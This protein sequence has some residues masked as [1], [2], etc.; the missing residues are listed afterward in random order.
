MA[1]WKRRNGRAMGLLQQ[2][3]PLL[4]RLGDLLVVKGLGLADQGPNPCTAVPREGRR[5]MGVYLNRGPSQWVD[6]SHYLPG[7]NQKLIAWEVSLFLNAFDMIYPHGS[8]AGG[9]P[10]QSDDWLRPAEPAAFA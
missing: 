7:L 4:A 8:W 9:R 2:L 10:S 3:L 6:W 1:L 5:I